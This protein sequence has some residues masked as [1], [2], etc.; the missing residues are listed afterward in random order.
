[1]GA[2]WSEIEYSPDVDCGRRWA[3]CSHQTPYG[4]ASC[5]WEKTDAGTEVTVVVP[6]GVRAQVK[7]PGKD[8]RVSEG[9]HTFLV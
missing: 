4:L 3:R 5:S 6:H 2:G 8:E 7:L 1:M 9:T